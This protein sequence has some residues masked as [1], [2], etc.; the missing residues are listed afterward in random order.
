MAVLVF[1]TIFF[2]GLEP[3]YL[4]VLFRDPDARVPNADRRTAAYP[5][6]LEEVARR[7]KPGDSIVLLAPIRTWRTGYGYAY[8]RA[9]YVLAG[10]NVIPILDDDD[11]VHRE[12][13]ADADYVAL[14]RMGPMP[15]YEVVWRSDEGTLLRRPR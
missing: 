10:R 3:L 1:V 8:Y 7:T 12:R 14:W 6:F 15:G 11:G 4:R 13:L 5:P 2:S 9:S